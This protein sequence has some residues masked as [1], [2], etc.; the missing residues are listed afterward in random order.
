MCVHGLTAAFF[1]NQDPIFHSLDWR[2]RVVPKWLES[3]WID[4]WLLL[5]VKTHSWLTP[6]FKWSLPYLQKEVLTYKSLFQ[7]C[8][9]VNV[10]VSYQWSGATVLTCF[11]FQGFFRI[12][13]PD[14][15]WM[16]QHRPKTFASF[17]VNC[18]NYALNVRSNYCLWLSRTFLQRF[19][20]TVKCF[21]RAHRGKKSTEQIFSIP[22]LS[23]RP[24]C[25]YLSC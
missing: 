6:A 25:S 16:P 8:H 18:G 21:S 24:F 17:P 20:Q 3:S 23:L 12:V 22:S 14:T 1:C 19:M 10:E 15:D 4:Y 5:T 7:C 11:F 13:M 9:M 2:C